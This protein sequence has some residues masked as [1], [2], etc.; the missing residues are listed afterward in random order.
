MTHVNSIG[1]ASGKAST[2]SII[3]PNHFYHWNRGSMSVVIIRIVIAIS[4]VPTCPLFY[5]PIGCKI[6]S[7][8]FKICE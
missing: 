7:H 5:C 6:M 1:K 8:A 3:G 2:D 4:F